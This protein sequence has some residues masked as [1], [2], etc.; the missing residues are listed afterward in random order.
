VLSF[1]R[2]LAV[3]VVAEGI[4][5]KEQLSMLR[6]M[7]CRIGQGYLFSRPIT[8]DQFCAL[9]ASEVRPIPAV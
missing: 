7:N 3:R 2:E 4:E 6:E 9:L 5:T 1:G 8:A